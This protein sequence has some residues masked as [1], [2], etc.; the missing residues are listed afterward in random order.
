MAL[1]TV[2][3]AFLTARECGSRRAGRLAAWSW[4]AVLPQVYYAKTMNL[5]APYLFWFA[6]ALLG[7]VRLRREPTVVHGLAF[8]GATAATLLTK[9]QAFG[10]FLFP[11]SSC[12]SSSVRGAAPPKRSTALPA[13]AAIALAAAATTELFGGTG[14]LAQHV[15]ELLAHPATFGFT[16]PGLGTPLGLLGLTGRHLAWSFGLPLAAR[17][18]GDRPRLGREWR[19]SR[20]GARP[21]HVLLLFPLSYLLATLLPLGYQYDRFL[22]P[23]L[24]VLVVAAAAAGDRWLGA[25]SPPRLRAALAAALQVGDRLGRGS[26]P[27]PSTPAPDRR[28]EVA[29]ER[30][31]RGTPQLAL[32]RHEVRPPQHFDRRFRVDRRSDP[33]ARLDRAV[34]VIPA[35]DL[36]ERSLS[37]LTLRPSSGQDSAASASAPRP[38]TSVPAPRLSRFHGVLSEPRQGSIRHCCS[39]CGSRRSLPAGNGS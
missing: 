2:R 29:L 8:G 12:C 31:T 7:F 11:L 17:R 35:A 26:C 3:L 33:P 20:E 28:P 24:Y 39:S 21:L 38:R 32:F 18:R 14:L 10:L 19:G 34:V 5:D 37:Q 22:L 25:S 15:D 16:A 30:E 9:D 13:A 36:G 27:R 4:L 6:L 23:V 1:A